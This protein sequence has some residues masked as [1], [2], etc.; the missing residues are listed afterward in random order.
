[1]LL[2]QCLALCCY[3]C[4]GQPCVLLQKR[5]P[6]SLCRCVRN[7]PT[8]LLRERSPGLTRTRTPQWHRFISLVPWYAWAA[9]GR[10]LAVCAGHVAFATAKGG[11]G[12][13][14]PCM[15]SVTRLCASA[16]AVLACP[17]G[18]G[19][20]PAPPDSH[21]L[22]RTALDYPPPKKINHSG[23][24]MH[25]ARRT[26]LH[27]RHLCRGMAIAQYS[28]TGG[29]GGALLQYSCNTMCQR[30]RRQCSVPK[31]RGRAYALCGCACGGASVAVVPHG[32]VVDAQGSP[33]TASPDGATGR[34]PSPLSDHGDESPPSSRGGR[35]LLEMPPAPAPA[36]A[37]KNQ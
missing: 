26:I 1:M 2:Q 3:R 16:A 37:P 35:I 8:L 31:G 6:L 17:A 28:A 34:P 9:P 7:A 23:G 21:A 25:L 19:A 4:R 5:T 10:C 22:C 29:R 27:E 33:A 24:R 12:T 18:A 15:N 13:A 30:G 20:V 36:P 32:R 14:W 11:V